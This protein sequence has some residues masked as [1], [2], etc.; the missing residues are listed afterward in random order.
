MRVWGWIIG[1]SLLML[2]G[3]L[4]CE[5]QDDETTVV[6][7]VGDS[8]LTLEEVNEQIPPD[9]SGVV[10]REEKEEFVRRW[11]DTEI[12]YR[13]ALR[14]GIHKEK[15]IKKVIDNIKREFLAAELVERELKD[16][17]NITPEEVEEYYRTHQESFTRD[18]LEVR[19][20]YL[21]VESRK[22]AWKVWRQLV[23]G[24]NFDKLLREHSIE[25][26]DLGYFSMDDVPQEIAEVV[27]SLRKG[28]ISKPVKSEL[29]YYIIQVVDRQGGGTV[30]PL[31]EVREE[32]VDKL[33]AAKQRDQLEK[34]MKG[35]KEK[36]VVEV[37]LEVLASH[38][39][40][41]LR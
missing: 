21:L 27:F 22:K 16:N 20:K 28:Q 1:L 12:L 25:G 29:G 8:V 26:G 11:I 40:S 34:L 13:E 39:E 10:T 4:Y 23:R 36:E 30:R 33:I 19:A 38:I 5:Q 14:R 17:T 41:G 37:H 32:I 9:Y 24:E 18:Q 31:E 3:G 7:R 6:A 2:I 35:L 15:R